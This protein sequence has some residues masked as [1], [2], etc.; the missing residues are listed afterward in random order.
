MIAEHVA[1]GRGLRNF[2]IETSDAVVVGGE[3]RHGGRLLASREPKSRRNR[4]G[5]NA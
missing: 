2:V 4:L 5:R 3:V 1:R